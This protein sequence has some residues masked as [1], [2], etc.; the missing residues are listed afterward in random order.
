MRRLCY[1]IIVDCSDH[2]LDFTTMS[3]HLKSLGPEEDPEELVRFREQ[4]K[5]EVEQN[6]RKAADEQGND[7]L[8]YTSGPSVQT[9]TATGPSK[10]TSSQTVKHPVDAKE[11]ISIAGVPTRP[12]RYRS[13]GTTDLASN[14]LANVSPAVEIYRLAVQHEQRSELDTA[15]RLYRDAFRKDPNVDKIYYK[16]EQQMRTPASTMAT[17]RHGHTRNKSDSGTIDNVTREAAKLSVTHVAG[18][19]KGLLASVLG[20]FPQKL[21]FEPEDQRQ[22][23]LLNKLPDEIIIISLRCLGTSAIERFAAVCR[24]A[25]VLTLESSIWKCV[26]LVLSF[27]KPC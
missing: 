12:L 25:R 16:L 23:V 5:K 10:E 1:V 22:P 11:A 8:N 15:L 7:S 3:L 26:I 17:S 13:Y 21:T 4:W 14:S 24:K 20:N 18:D 19:M 9:S 2:S 27:H 6:R